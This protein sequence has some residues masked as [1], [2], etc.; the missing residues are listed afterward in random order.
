MNLL[1][2]LEKYSAACAY[3][4]SL[5][6]LFTWENRQSMPPEGTAY[7]Q[8]MMQFF[9]DQAHATRIGS[10]AREL[11]D[12]LNENPPVDPIH[13]A[14]YRDL[15]RNLSLANVPSPLIAER[16]R[17]IAQATAAWE[18]ANHANDARLWLSQ[19]QRMMDN[20]RQIAEAIVPDVH[21]FEFWV[22]QYEYDLPLQSLELLFVD[23]RRELVALRSELPSR[24]VARMPEAGWGRERLLPFC[25]KL[26]AAAGF[27]ERIGR[28]GET[29]LPFSSIIGPRDIRIAVNFS[30]PH[31]A[32]SGTL[33]E[34]GHAIYAA[35]V[36]PAF[37]DNG[38]W[39]P[40]IGGYDEAMA[41]LW[42]RMIGQS[43]EFWQVFYPRLQAE[44]SEFASLSMDE[45]LAGFKHVCAEPIRAGSDE[46][47]Y[48]LHILIRFELEKGLVEGSLRAV[49]LPDAWKQLYERD[50][51]VRTADDRSGCLQDIHWSLGLVGYFPSYVLGSVM[52][53]QIYRAMHSA[54]ILADMAEGN[55][56]PV[57]QW[58]GEHCYLQGRLHTPGQILTK[59]AGKDQ[60]LDDYLTYLREKYLGRQE[61]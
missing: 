6:E 31:Q 11:V 35:G 9:G 50:L 28:W 61:R 40:F 36:D 43:R 29:R 19:I 14:M 8:M 12:Q 44:F 38:L 5:G 42:E 7:R 20:S 58:L 1:E 25:Q 52:A 2:R 47:T 41:I 51:Q 22:N 24:E 34:V 10:Q 32:F 45:Y 55:F 33:H 49:D 13:Q 15:Q 3:H 18:E 46:I 16:Q 60:G 27:D 57:R 17:V 30:T 53:A 48:P 26:A 56:Q 4:F 37:H 54:G 23:L 21:P 39:V 59:V